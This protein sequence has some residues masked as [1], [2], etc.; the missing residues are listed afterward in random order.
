MN[1]HVSQREGGIFESVCGPSEEPV[2]KPQI[3]VWASRLALGVYVTVGG[4]PAVLAFAVLAD[5]M[6][7]SCCSRSSRLLTV[8][9]VFLLLG[10]DDGSSCF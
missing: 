5:F 4:S 8:V 2:S 7:E 6:F 10:L 3:T 9:S 1:F